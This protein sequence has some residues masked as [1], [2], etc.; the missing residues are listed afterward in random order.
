MPNREDL[1]VHPMK[2]PSLNSP[3]NSASSEPESF[4]LSEGYQPMLPIRNLGDLRINAR[5]TGR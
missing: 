1:L 2:T 3:L 5:P 4:Q